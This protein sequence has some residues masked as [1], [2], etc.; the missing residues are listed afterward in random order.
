MTLQDITNIIDEKVNKNS[1][2]IVFS[3]YE[4]EVKFKL[5]KEEKIAF[6]DLAETRLRNMGYKVYREGQKY[7]YQNKYLSLIPQEKLVAIKE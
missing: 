5:S 6:L 7:F 1:D 4:I 2:K 3:Y